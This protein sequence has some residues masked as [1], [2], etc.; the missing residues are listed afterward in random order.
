M[1][2]RTSGPQRIGEILRELLEASGLGGKLKH[3]EVYTAWDD[4]IGPELGRHARIAGFAHHRL[5][6]D[7]DSAAHLHELRTFHKERLLK[8][9][10][11]KLPSLLI[12][13]IVF[14][15]AAIQQEMR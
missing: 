2:K 9:L 5:Y 1:I 3:I 10:R 8:I 12:R 7:V 14:R 13:D 4:A 15:P 6:V 11:S